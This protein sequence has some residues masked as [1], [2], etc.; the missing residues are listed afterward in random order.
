MKKLLAV[1]VASMMATTVQADIQTDLVF[2]REGVMEPGGE[3]FNIWHMQVTTNTDWFFSHLT[4]SLTTGSFGKHEFGGYFPPNPGLVDLFP[5]LVNDTYIQNPAGGTP[6]LATAVGATLFPTA[7]PSGDTEVHLGWRDTTNTGSG[8]F[9]IGQFALSADASGTVT[10][11]S[12]DTETIGAGRPLGYRL[13][14]PDLP[15][16]WN[17]VEGEFIWTPE[18]AT[19]SL[20]ALGGLV[21]R[22]KRRP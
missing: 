6:H 13:G 1:A 17:V 22:H 19:L 5:E 8:T 14:M 10:G 15:G 3:M 18:P 9:T 11:H 20:L 7:F 2:V 4:I 16:Q 21:L 12:W